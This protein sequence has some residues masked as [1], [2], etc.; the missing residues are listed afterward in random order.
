MVIHIIRLRM[1][2][3]NCTTDENI[4][5]T[6]NVCYVKIIHDFARRFCPQ[7]VVSSLSSKNNVNKNIV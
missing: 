4:S 3:E 5:S 7:G 1:T 6:D 2:F